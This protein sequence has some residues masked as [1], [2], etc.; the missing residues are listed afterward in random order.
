M[1]TVE[2]YGKNNLSKVLL[3]PNDKLLSLSSTRILS[4]GL[5]P[6]NFYE[7]DFANQLNLFLQV[8]EDFFLLPLHSIRAKCINTNI[9]TWVKYVM[10]IG[11]INFQKIKTHIEADEKTIG[12]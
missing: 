4:L 11:Y 2:S 7:I 6:I 10:D 12:Q 9:M 1:V 3:E 8:Q 5:I